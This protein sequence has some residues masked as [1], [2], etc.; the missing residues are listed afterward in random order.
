VPA[1]SIKFFPYFP[2]VTGFDSIGCDYR[3]RLLESLM[4]F[5]T[6]LIMI[7]HHA[8]EHPSSDTHSPSSSQSIDEN[9]EIY[10]ACLARLS[11]FKDSEG[12]YKCL[13]EDAMQHPKLDQPLIDKLVVLANSQDRFQ[14]GLRSAATKV[15]VNYKLDIEG[16]S[17]EGPATTVRSHGAAIVLR[18][19]GSSVATFLGSAAS[20]MLNVIG[21]NSRNEQ[22]DPNLYRPV[23]L[24]LLATHAHVEPPHSFEEGDSGI[25]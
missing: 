11:D 5:L 1:K 19:A 10:V 3:P 4:P 24:E 21:L 18:E 23:E 2:D 8:P 7:S 6:L 13:W 14:D 20:W 9:L 25:V 12:S 16:N 22:G 15:L 17:R